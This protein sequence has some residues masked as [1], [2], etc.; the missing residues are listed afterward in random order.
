[1][2]IKG[3]WIISLE[4][5]MNKAN[6]TVSLLSPLKQL[7]IMRMRIDNQVVLGISRVS[8]RCIHASFRTDL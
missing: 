4:E 5:M 1:M 8:G 6:M 7:V 2:L 3:M